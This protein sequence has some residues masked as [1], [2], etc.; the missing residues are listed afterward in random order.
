VDGE[1]EHPVVGVEDVLGAVAVVD[2]P[3]E[4]G[5]PPDPAREGVPAATAAWL[6]RQNPIP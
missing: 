6:V 5:H 4:E 1:V 3:V 2:V